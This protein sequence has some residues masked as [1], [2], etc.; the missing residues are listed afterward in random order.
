MKL[1]A[2]MAVAFLVSCK[3]CTCTHEA[4]ADR[5]PEKKPAVPRNIMVA[6][7]GLLIGDPHA[8]T[9]T[10][11]ERF[12]FTDQFLIVTAHTEALPAKKVE[13]YFFKLSR[14]D[15]IKIWD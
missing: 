6:G 9:F 2:L 11:V 3:P 8:F 1:I 12:E 14:V 7:A 15:L 10:E 13:T 5:L 4:H